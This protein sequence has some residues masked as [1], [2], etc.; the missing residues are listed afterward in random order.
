MRIQFF[1]DRAAKRFSLAEIMLVRAAEGY[2]SFIAG[3]GMFA[4][5]C[6]SS[7]RD[8]AIKGSYA[9]IAKRNDINSKKRSCK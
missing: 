1:L 7:Y 8:T 5:K 9:W 2:R 4:N 3:K 6:A